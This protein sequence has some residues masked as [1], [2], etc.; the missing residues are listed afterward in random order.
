MMNNVSDDLIRDA[1]DMHIH[2]NPD[3]IPRL[4]TDIQIAQAAKAAGMAG[5][6]IKCHYT[7]TTA[8]AALAAETVGGGIRVFGGIVMNA[9]AGGLN[10]DAV[11]TELALG[12]KEVWMPTIWSVAHLRFY[13]KA[14][15][16]AVQVTDEQGRLLPEVY[17]ILALI[18]QKDAIL[19]TGHLLPSETALVIKAAQAC[20]VRKILV[21]HPE[22]EVVRMPVEMQKDLA[23]QGVFFERCFYATHSPQ[24]LPPE[25]LVQQ[26][27]AVGVAT[28]VLS[29]DFG[30]V[31]NVP[32]VNGLSGLLSLML[33]NGIS[34]PE[35]ER[36]VKVNP[37][38]LLGI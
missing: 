12:A 29:S 6:L 18:A 7:P 34:V 33:E 9:P 28:T 3:I 30:Q 36:M 14:T 5:I 10:P 31:F 26:V 27:K 4:M 35:I 37:R 13:K 32:P 24:K 17:E 16:Q 23:R 8:R 2:S 19:G 20:G 15:N 21:T 22:F 11:E 25:E 1:I 38:Y